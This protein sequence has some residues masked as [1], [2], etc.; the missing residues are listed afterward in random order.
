MNSPA[1]SGGP[2]AGQRRCQLPADVSG[3]VGRHGE[4][5]RLARLLDG[6]RLVTVTGPGGV[7]KTR[8]A[9]RAAASGGYAGG[10][11]LVE[12]SGLTDAE[13][14]PDIVAERLGLQCPDLRDGKAAAGSTRCSTSFAAGSCC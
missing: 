10:N 11:C 6:A 2:G 8:L 5:S 3:F 7:G 12:L 13:L 4:L 14:L 9:V 1:A